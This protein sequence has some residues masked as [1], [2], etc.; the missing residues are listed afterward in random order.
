MTV[1]GFGGP[2]VDLLESDADSGEFELP[3]GSLPIGV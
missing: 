1:D 2:V 3:S